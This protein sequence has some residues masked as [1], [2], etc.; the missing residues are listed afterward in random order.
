MLFLRRSG[1]LRSLCNLY[2]ISKGP[3]G[4][5][6]F[7]RARAQRGRQP[8]AGSIYPNHPAPV[9]RI[10]DDGECELAM[11]QS[12]MPSPSACM[13]GADRGVRTVRN[14]ALPHWRRWLVVSSRRVVA[15]MSFA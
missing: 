6:G 13:K 9:A 2:N 4:I 5:L 8:R 7:T 1:I 10:T 11:R 12:G 14:A 3:V 15:A